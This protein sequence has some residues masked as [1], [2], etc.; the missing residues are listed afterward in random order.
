VDV[1]A[2]V[3][4]RYRAKADYAHWH[5]AL[6]NDQGSQ[7]SVHTFTALT[8]WWRSTARPDSC[9]GCVQYA[10]QAGCE[11]VRCACK[12][13]GWHLDRGGL[14]DCQEVAG[15]QG[16]QWACGALETTVAPSAPHSCGEPVGPHSE[17]GRSAGWVNGERKTGTRFVLPQR[18]LRSAPSSGCRLRVPDALLSRCRCSKH[19]CSIPSARRGITPCSALLIGWGLGGANSSRLRSILA[20]RRACRTA[21]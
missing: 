15:C 2:W 17:A 14:N 13:I 4:C 8:L 11:S 10:T 9:L 1:L 18:C 21:C 7:F 3:S 20:R 5:A 19:Q 6:C 16:W 12:V